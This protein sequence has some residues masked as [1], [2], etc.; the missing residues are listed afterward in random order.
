MVVVVVLVDIL[1][2]MCLKGCEMVVI[3]VEY[4]CDKGMKVLLLIDF[5]ICYVMV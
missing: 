5:L 2:F 3:I 4:F 1:L